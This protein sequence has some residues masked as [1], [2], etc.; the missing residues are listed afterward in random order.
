MF[1]GVRGVFPKFRLSDDH[2]QVVC[3]TCGE[4]YPLKRLS[5]FRIDRARI[6]HLCHAREK[7][8]QA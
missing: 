6:V 4:V 5:I 7:G 8:W 2:K 1:K 3:R